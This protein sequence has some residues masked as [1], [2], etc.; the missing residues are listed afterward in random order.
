MYPDVH[1][2]RYGSLSL[3]SC[4]T[5]FFLFFLFEFFLTDSLARASTPF[6]PSAQTA[7]NLLSSKEQRKIQDNYG[8]LPLA[9][10]ENRGQMDQSVRFMTQN[11]Q[12]SIFF[13]Q[14]E[15]V[16]RPAG[17]ASSIKNR[18]TANRAGKSSADTRIADPAWLHRNHRAGLV[19]MTMSGMKKDGKILTQEPMAGKVNYLLGNDPKRWHTNIPTYGT[20]LYRKVYPGIDIKFYGN[21]RKLEYDVIVQPGADP[22]QV[23]ISFSGIAGYEILKNGDLSLRLPQGGEFV[24][25]AP[26]IYQ[27]IN[28]RSVIR[29]G[30]LTVLA[31][32]GDVLDVTLNRADKDQTLV[33]GFRLGSYDKKCPLI[34]DPVLE[35]STYLGGSADENPTGGIAVDGAGNAYVT[36]TTTSTDFPTVNAIDSIYQNNGAYSTNGDA[37]VTKMNANGSAL[38]YS[39][40]LGGGGIEHGYDIVVDGSGNAIV[41]GTTRSSDFPT[42]NAHDSTFAL[43]SD[44][45][46]SKLNANGS[47][48][49]YSTFLG[50]NWDDA[51]Y[52]IDV[53][54]AGNVYVTGATYST[55]FPVTG[56]AIG[57][58][59]NGDDDAFVAKFSDT[60]ALLYATYLGGSGSDDGMEGDI[61]VDGSGNMY[62]TGWTY[63]ADFPTLNAMDATLGGQNDAFVVKLQA[64]GAALVYATY[65]GGSGSDGGYGI[66]VDS[67]GNAHVVGTTVSDDFPTANALFPNYIGGGDAF[68]SKFNSAGTN[69]VY[70]TYLGGPYGDY[71]KDIVVDGLGNAY[72]GGDAGDDFPTTDPPIGQ[73]GVFVSR[74]NPGGT[75]LEYSTFVGGSA[76]EECYGIAVDPSGNVYLAGISYSEDFPTVNAIKAILE[77]YTRDAFVCKIKG[78]GEDTR[79]TFCPAIPYLLLE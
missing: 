16:F 68:V 59:R 55:D 61:A 73:N 23:R 48:F 7:G 66:A 9:F 42:F 26:F 2:H 40:Y 65:L 31:Q 24:Q 57:S 47:A 63:S 60:G 34:I 4:L 15:I 36:G 64:D 46:V 52:G 45:F 1:D 35:Y 12:Y 74:F 43:R 20:L 58:T 51:G 71:G 19:R 6:V 79:L 22:S 33:V 18:P 13:L 10:T 75:V 37:F 49:V 25:K 56:N 54:A 72:V 67:A 28:G 41:T 30:K 76:S 32:D 50:G 39:T 14:D 8:S 69:F 11:S 77:E 53:D 62:V 29:E 70:S 21:N 3:I 44:A 38:V 5:F 27:E 78:T 17:T